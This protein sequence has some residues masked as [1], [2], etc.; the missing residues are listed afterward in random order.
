MTSSPSSSGIDTSG[1]NASSPRKRARESDSDSSS[2]TIDSSPT[3]RPKREAHITFHPDTHDNSLWA[4]FFDSRSPGEL[5]NEGPAHRPATPFRPRTAST[6]SSVITSTDDGTITAYLDQYREFLGEPSKE[7]QDLK[8]IENEGRQFASH[9]Y[10]V[11]NEPPIP[12]GFSTMDEYT[13]DDDSDS[14]ASIDSDD[15]FIEVIRLE[16]S[17]FPGGIYYRTTSDAADTGSPTPEFDIEPPRASPPPEV[18]KLRY[19][20]EKR[21]GFITEDENE[22]DPVP[23][24]GGDK[25]PEIFTRPPP[26]SF[27]PFTDVEGEKIKEREE[28]NSARLEKLNPANVGA[29]SLAQR[30]ASHVEPVWNEPTGAD[31]QIDVIEHCLRIV[32]DA[33]GDRMTAHVALEKLRKAWSAKAWEEGVLEA[34][35]AEAEK[36]A[37][38]QRMLVSKDK[39]KGKA[40]A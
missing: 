21:M 12:D 20:Q 10:N 39:G 3:K 16:D 25:P 7:E 29:A 9:S 2:T 6:I 24:P 27:T 8:R 11:P 30:A 18:R 14:S 36:Q 37:E 32:K 34:Q 23:P 4:G 5:Q 15:E 1:N 19:E 28:A 38:A 35:K 17:N 31:S 26:T 40:K 22:K 13:H 33:I